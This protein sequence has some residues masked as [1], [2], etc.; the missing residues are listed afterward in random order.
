M[1]KGHKGYQRPVDA[2]VNVVVDLGGECHAGL[3]GSFYWGPGEGP[4]A[5]GRI[6]RYVTVPFAPNLS[7]RTS[8]P[9]LLAVST[10]NAATGLHLT[11]EQGQAILDIYGAFERAA[12]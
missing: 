7:L 10:F 3:A 5:L 2:G 4:E 9:V 1:F 12:Q 11:E 6:K 8:P